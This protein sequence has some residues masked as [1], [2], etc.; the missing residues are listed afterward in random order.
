M[1]RS[2]VKFTIL[3]LLAVFFN[4]CMSSNT[5][6]KVKPDGS[7][8]IEETVLMGKQFVQQ[9]KAM[10]GQMKAQMPEGQD[11]GSAP[12][13]MF[14]L[15]NIEKIKAKAKDLGEGVTYVESSEVV[16]E[17]H[18]GY[19]AV[20]AFT[21]INNLKFNQNPGGNVPSGPGGTSNPNNEYV[22]FNFT[23][24]DPSLLVIIPPKDNG[25]NEAEIEENVA[26]DTSDAPEPGEAEMA[27]MKQMFDGMKIALY[28]EIDGEIVKTNATHVD[29]NRITIMEMDFGELIQNAE[30]FKEYAKAKPKTVEESKELMKDMPGIKIDLNEK[31][32][33]QFK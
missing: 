20:Y 27:Q 18:E 11:Q 31:M 10:M 2:S 26:E 30:K 15:Y 25:E 8:T 3:L 24:G 28:L 4:G 19:K 21:D 33:V 5:I 32:E 14:N 16:N 12:T 13:E 1:N 6:I 29:K 7:G 17:T 22:T 9:M 23:K